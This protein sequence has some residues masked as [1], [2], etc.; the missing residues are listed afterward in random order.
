MD[1]TNNHILIYAT[2]SECEKIT[3]TAHQEYFSSISI[4]DTGEELL[5]E[6]KTGKLSHIFPEKGEHQ[7]AVRFKDDLTNLQECF[8]EC[9][10]LQS[11]PSGLFD[12]CTKVKDF[13]FCFYSTG[14][15]EIPERLFE[16]CIEVEEFNCCFSGCK[17]LEDIR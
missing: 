7:V 4:P 10:N 3:L 2:N 5:R 11:I 1:A 17:Y 16:Q 14:I 6:G 12:K 15:K 9:Y 13:S 8:I